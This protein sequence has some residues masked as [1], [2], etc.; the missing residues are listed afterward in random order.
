MVSG[1]ETLGSIPALFDRHGAAIFRRCRALLGDGDA[2]HD[3]VQE[4]F[5]RAF[6]KQAEFRGEASPL[7]WLYGMATLHCLQQL[8]NRGRR[9]DKLATWSVERTALG[10]SRDEDR[11]TLAALIADA[12]VDVQ[13][14]VVLRIIDEMTADEV[15]A[16][17]GLSRKTVTKK[18]QTFLSSAR[19][20]I[21]PGAE[22]VEVPA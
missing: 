2:A 11:L 17:V 16:A 22:K 18:L 5:L 20:R 15:A 10:S 3:A 13:Q 7:T 19:A 1:M 4:V 9:A 8:R 14:I 12:S 6:T 21:A